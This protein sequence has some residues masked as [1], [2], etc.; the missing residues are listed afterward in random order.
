MTFVR[1]LVHLLGFVSVGNPYV[2][3]LHDPQEHFT[4]S[5]IRN[6][7]QILCVSVCVCV[8]EDESGA[9]DDLFVNGNKNIFR[10]NRFAKK[11]T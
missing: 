2:T 5:N 6:G 9:Y 4:M 11:N 1:H 7:V 8:C 3:I 10:K